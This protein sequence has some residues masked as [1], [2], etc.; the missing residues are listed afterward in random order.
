MGGLGIRAGPPEAVLQLWAFLRSLESE[1]Y[2][3]PVQGD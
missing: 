1:P 2:Q 3:N